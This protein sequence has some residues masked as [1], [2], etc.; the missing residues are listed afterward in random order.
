MRLPKTTNPLGRRFFEREAHVA[1][2]ERA[3]HRAA[4]LLWIAM[5][6][7]SLTSTASRE[8]T[9]TLKSTRLT[10]RRS[11][12]EQKNPIEKSP[13][14]KGRFRLAES[15]CVSFCWYGVRTP[16]KVYVLA[17][18][19][20]L[21]AHTDQEKKNT[22]RVCAPCV[23]PPMSGAIQRAT[24]LPFGVVHPCTPRTC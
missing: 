17:D 2:G 10:I 14:E 12:K 20:Y 5:E 7:Y 13:V 23:T 21:Y 19:V 16:H 3:K 9:K 1:R 4:N 6:Q 22:P 24:R 18:S 8:S 11:K 15:D